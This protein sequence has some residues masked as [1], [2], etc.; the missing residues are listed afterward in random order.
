MEYKCFVVFYV[1]S[2]PPA[3]SVGTLNLIA[4]IPGSFIFTSKYTYLFVNLFFP[5]RFLSG[6]F[7]LIA[8]FPD[9]CLLVPLYDEDAR[10]IPLKD[11]FWNRV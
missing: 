7:F 9:H 6:N 2:F 4:S 10:A 1:F 3:V 11:Q 8:P 5:A